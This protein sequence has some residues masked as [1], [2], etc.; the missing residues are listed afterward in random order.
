MRSMEMDTPSTIAMLTVLECHS[1]PAGTMLRCEAGI[2]HSC[3]EVRKGGEGAGGEVEAE[4]A[5]EEGAVGWG[6]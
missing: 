2:D 1:T 6:G 5:E 4:H 3:D